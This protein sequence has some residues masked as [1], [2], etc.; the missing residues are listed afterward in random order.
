MVYKLN[1]RRFAPITLALLLFV[2]SLSISYDTAH[3]DALAEDAAILAGTASA[4]TTAKY[5]ISSLLVAGGASVLGSS[6]ANQIK[7]E[8][9][10]I[11]NKTSS[12]TQSAWNSAV[13]SSISA[14]KGTVTFT[15]DMVNDLKHAFSGAGAWLSSLLNT[16]AN[17]TTNASPLLN[18]PNMGYEVLSDSTYW[19]IIVYSGSGI[20]VPTVSSGGV[21]LKN[22]GTVNLT[23]SVY[24]Q[25]KSSFSQPNW[26]GTKT[27]I[28]DHSIYTGSDWFFSYSGLSL[29]YDVKNPPSTVAVPTGTTLDGVMSG[30]LDNLANGTKEVAIPLDNFIY[31]DGAGTI[32]DYSPTDTAF[33]YPST[34]AVYTGDVAVDYPI[35]GVDTPV[36]YGNPTV[37]LSDV[38]VDGTTTFPDAPAP[39]D[40]Y[41]DGNIDWSKLLIAFGS[42]TDVFPFSIPWDVS[43]LFSVLNVN[44]QTPVF[45]IN[46]QKNI[47]ILGTT[48]PIKYQFNIDFSAF[49]DVAMIGRWAL[50]LIWDIAII[51]GL[52]RFTPD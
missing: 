13:A 27:D 22:T 40:P 23:V 20:I 21:D 26:N 25:L 36:S 4:V 32:L 42:L 49:N 45:N 46:I 48:I 16:A 10:N 17:P 8:A 15:Q 24:Q 41:S 5:V 52:R 51:M 35:P 14:G 43:S 12:A 3:A 19:Y 31:K 1:F 9:N 28:M 47:S 18:A 44:P 7:T 29:V 38:T 39:K 34:G 30:D 50:V 37:G 2:G 11:W 6:Y 33:V